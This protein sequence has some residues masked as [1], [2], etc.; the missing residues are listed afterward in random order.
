MPGITAAL[1]DKEG[2]PIYT[3]VVD[4]PLVLDTSAYADGDVLAIPQEVTGVGTKSGSRFALHS[5]I[6]LDEDDQNQPFDL[7][8]FNA[9]AELGTI[10]AAVSISDADA[11]KII[12]YVEMTT[13]ESRDLVN[14]RL[15]VASGIG[16]VMALASS[17][18]SLWVGAI[19]RGTGT[20]TA[21]G[22]RLKLG[23]VGV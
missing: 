16:Q 8:F 13:A 1:Q 10:N 4:V 6:A 12:G 22:I 15:F 7:V 21:S 17:T 9:S 3:D 19:S 20:Y 18:N 2:R 14:S 5:I 23:F 11:R